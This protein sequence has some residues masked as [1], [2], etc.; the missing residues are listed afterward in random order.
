[1]SCRRSH[2]ASQEGKAP[3]S[4]VMTSAMRD[5][6]YAEKADMHRMY[7]RANGIDR[8]AQRMY[9]AQFSD[10]RIPDHRT[11]QWLHCQL[12]KH[13]HST[14]PDMVLVVEAVGS[15]CLE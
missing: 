6:R 8:T 4:I 12:R 11:F 10:R 1:M 13:V 2:D 5:F 15:P 14:S 3:F 9:H 7:I